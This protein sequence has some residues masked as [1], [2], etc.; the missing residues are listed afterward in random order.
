MTVL[1]P[2]KKQR[3]C[4]PVFVENL[5][6]SRYTCG[7]RLPLSEIHNWQHE[8][9]KSPFDRRCTS[10][11]ITT[12]YNPPHPTATHWLASQLATCASAAASCYW[13]IVVVL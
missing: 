7:Q 2:I 6:A 1:I 11:P 4:F 5:L 10:L 3:S 13:R 8:I 12:N 9:D